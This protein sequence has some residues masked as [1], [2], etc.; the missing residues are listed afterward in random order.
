[1]TPSREG[2]LPKGIVEVYTGDGKGK[3]TAA[4]GLALRALGAGLRVAVLQFL[5]GGAH[6]S[7][8]AMLPRLGPRLWVQRFADKVTP[9]GLGQG[10]PTPEDFKA[11]ATGWE[12]AVEVI[13]SGAW[14]V[15]ILDEINN[16]L[17]ARLL[18]VEDVLE[19]LRRRPGHVEVVCTGRGAPE[20]L[21]E[22]AELI[23]EMR[24]ARHPY[25]RDLGARR[26]IED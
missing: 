22:A 12:A 3:T 16:V 25:D 15:V 7:E 8:L 20:E 18:D 2:H 6:T 1:M 19:V 9:F 4:L 21:L 10:E 14:D 11:V 23:T 26:G 17:A 13:A 5:K 24:N